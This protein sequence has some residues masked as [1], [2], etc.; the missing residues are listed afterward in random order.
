MPKL[1]A[2]AFAGLPDELQQEI[3]SQ[4]PIEHLKDI[5]IIQPHDIDLD[6]VTER[7][8]V[9][10][11]SLKQKEAITVIIELIKALNSTRLPDD[12]P[13]ELKLVADVELLEAMVEHARNI[14]KESGIDI[15]GEDDDG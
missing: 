10:L 3:L 6:E 9:A 12:M 5:R 11:L 14:I 1:T 7:L 15:E 4:V 13:Q 8:R 2:E